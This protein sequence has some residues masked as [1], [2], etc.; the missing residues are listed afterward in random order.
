MLH[1]MSKKQL[2]TTGYFF[3]STRGTTTS[4]SFS[5]PLWLMPWGST[6]VSRTR[7]WTS[8]KFQDSSPSF[9]ILLAGLWNA[10]R[11]FTCE[12]FLTCTCRAEHVQVEDVTQ[13]ISF[14]IA[15]TNPQTRSEYIPKT[16]LEAAIQWVNARFELLFTATNESNW[17]T[18]NRLS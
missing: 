5:E 12:C 3:F 8:R 13:R 4:C 15:A 18:T 6:T 10:L 11:M 7:P 14:Y 17:F 16:D 1:V 2:L 9:S